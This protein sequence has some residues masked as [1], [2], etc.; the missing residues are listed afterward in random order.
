MFLFAGRV[1]YPGC[2]RRGW[3]AGRGG[4]F[5]RA[6]A[7]FPRP[8]LF[9]DPE[10][11]RTIMPSPWRAHLVLRRLLRAPVPSARRSPRAGSARAA[12]VRG[13]TLRLSL[14]SICACQW[15][16][17]AVLRAADRSGGRRRREKGLLL[18]HITTSRRSCSASSPASPS[19]ATGPGLSAGLDELLSSWSVKDGSARP[20]RRWRT[21]WMLRGP[22]ARARLSPE[23]GTGAMVA[24]QSLQ[25]PP[26]VEEGVG[27]RGQLWGK[28]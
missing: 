19:S 22:L 12:P 17:A 23:L 25:D 20:P 1:D 9:P 3:A 5:S 2:T 16:Q 10:D 6:P 21:C 4:G 27:D 7:L 24:I 28:A 11:P 15:R 13:R 18:L 26:L 8:V 14:G